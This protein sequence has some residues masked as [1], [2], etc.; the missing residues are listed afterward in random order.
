M[1]DIIKHIPV[2]LILPVLLLL[3][4][5]S[6]FD[7]EPAESQTCLLYVAQA[8]VAT[9][10]PAA[11]II[12]HHTVKAARISVPVIVGGTVAP[13]RT[14]TLKAQANGTVRYLAGRE[15][16]AFKAGA[17]LADISVNKLFARRQAA[18][19]QLQNAQSVIN[20]AQIQ[21]QREL[22]SPQSR[23]LSKSG[24]MGM[25]MMFDQ[26]FGRTFS[27]FLPDNIGG[28]SALDRSADLHNMGTQLDQARGHYSQIQAQIDEI[29][30]RIADARINTPF[31]GIILS[32]MV[33][34]GDTVQ[35][36]TPL[37]RYA[38][39][40]HLQL[41]AQVPA[42]VV[43]RL[44][45]NMILPVRLDGSEYEINARVGQIFPIA[46]AQRRT[47]TVKLDLPD[48][49]GA[50]PGMY[51]ELSL[52]GKKNDERPTPVIPLAAV[53]FTGSLPAVKVLTADNQT[54]LRVI[55]LGQ[56]IA[57]EQVAVI[58]GLQPGE[59]IIQQP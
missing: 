44:A 11:P 43:S 2:I 37:L 58:S 47:V 35:M 34:T 56:R 4:V 24:G 20:N 12:P 5:W 27:N 23:S 38:N 3:G 22:F 25:P 17:L 13:A 32:K 53:A 39:L 57:G 8:D 7:S 26:M 41:E 36:G 46:N 49:S 40:N 19:A 28:D 6:L 33:E 14:V 16:D 21:Y 30:A 42:S 15:G 50:I 48:N 10:K 31:P 52:P 45:P 18:L 55:R 59:R 54:Q 9:S 1:F 29:D 51:A